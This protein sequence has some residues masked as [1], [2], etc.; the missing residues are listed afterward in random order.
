EAATALRAI[1]SS[2]A[3]VG[4]PDLIVTERDLTRAWSHGLSGAEPV[5]NI[6]TDHP[7]VVDGRL[8]VDEAAALMLNGEIRHLI[9]FDDGQVGIV[10]IRTVMGV[11]LQA[12]RP[13]GWLARLRSGITDAPEAWLG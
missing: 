4:G 3:L 13:E 9:V 5:S 7:L 2:A 1:N 8:S 6:A 10:S 11:L 12:I